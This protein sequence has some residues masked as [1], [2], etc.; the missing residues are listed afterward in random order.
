MQAYV[1]TFHTEAA[2][3]RFELEQGSV[4]INLVNI[5]EAGSY[6]VPVQVTLDKGV[7][8]YKEVTVQITLEEDGVI[9]KEEESRGSDG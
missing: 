3:N 9:E 6:N 8:L 4:S 5:K 1:I 7:V 2:L